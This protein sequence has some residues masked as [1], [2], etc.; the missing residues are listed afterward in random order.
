MIASGMPEMM[1]PMKAM[2]MGVM[3]QFAPVKQQLEQQYPDGMNEDNR[4]EIIGQFMNML[5]EMASGMPEYARDAIGKGVRKARSLDELWEFFGDAY[6]D[7][8]LK[9]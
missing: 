4:E 8:T 7:M 9:A 1:D 6:T 5:T 2:M 3:M